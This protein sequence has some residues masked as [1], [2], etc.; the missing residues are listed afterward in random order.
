MKKLIILGIF[1]LGLVGLWAQRGEAGLFDCWHCH[2][3]CDR[4][5]THITIRQ[6]NAFS[7]VCSGNV[8]CQGCTPSCCFAGIGGGCC[9]PLPPM[10]PPAF[11]PFPPMFPPFH[12]GME[13]PTCFNSGCCDTPCL[14][15]PH[16]NPPTP[17][18]QPHPAVPAD[19]NF[20][21]PPPTPLPA[22]SHQYAPAANPF[23]TVG[24]Y[25]GGYPYYYPMP[26][27]NP[28]MMQGGYNPYYGYGYYQNPNG[29]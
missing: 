11:C 25:Q 27:Y 20:N 28:W 8:F 10:M 17:P 5:S 3:K 16:G 29:Y 14:P 21:P 19:P 12:H 22:M 26:T 23:Q 1:S 15:P 7:P 6:Y 9:P 2:R 24:Y 4:F 18:H 13:P